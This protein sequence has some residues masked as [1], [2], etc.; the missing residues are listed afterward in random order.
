MQVE[1][2]CASVQVEVCRWKCGGS[3]V[4]QCAGGSVV[5]VCR[6]KSGVE[7]CSWKCGVAVC[8]DE[9]EVCAG[10]SLKPLTNDRSI[11][12]RTSHTERAFDILNT[13]RR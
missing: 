11:F 1:V 3:V 4:W 8:M 5:E 10:L 7:V 2:W 12:R 13:L 6:W 9:P